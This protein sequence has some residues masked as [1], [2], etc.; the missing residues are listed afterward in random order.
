MGGR[1][2]KSTI[3][4]NNNLKFLNV[5]LYH[6]CR[7][8]EGIEYLNLNLRCLAKFLFFDIN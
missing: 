2:M 5:L 4:N 3:I 8:N 1:M 7:I 6:S